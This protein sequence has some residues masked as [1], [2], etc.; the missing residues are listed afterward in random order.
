MRAAKGGLPNLAGPK[1]FLNF[2]RG[3]LYPVFKTPWD[4]KGVKTNQFPL[5]FSPRAVGSHSKYFVES[6]LNSSTP[7]RNKHQHSTWYKLCKHISSCRIGAS[8]TRFEK[9]KEQKDTASKMACFTQLPATRQT[10]TAVAVVML[11][12]LR[13]QLARLPCLHFAGPGIQLK[14]CNRSNCSLVSIM[15]NYKD[16]AKA[17]KLHKVLSIYM[18]RDSPYPK[19]L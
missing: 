17:S 3:A 10:A 16:T 6:G 15:M 13:Q 18:E 1:I 9:W 14:M 11:I 7:S 5:I 2:A 12:A 4:W 19:K 8:K